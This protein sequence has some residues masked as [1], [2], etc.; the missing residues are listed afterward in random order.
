MEKDN[1]QQLLENIFFE[2]Q[3]KNGNKMREYHVDTHPVF[4]DKTKYK[5]ELLIRRNPSTRP[6]MMVGQDE[7]VFKQYSF[8]RK[9]WVGPGGETQLLPKSEGYSKMV[10]GF[11]SRDFGVGLHLDDNE[12][13]KVNKQRVSDEWCHYLSTGA[14]LTVNGTTQKKRNLKIISP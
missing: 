10:S 1:N 13:Q 3:D 7:S 8:G 14:A 11:V 2:L 5:K 9:C 4:R 12:I 6:M